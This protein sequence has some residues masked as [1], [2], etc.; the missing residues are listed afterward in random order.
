MADKLLENKKLVRDLTVA[1]YEVD[2]KKRLRPSAFMDYAQ[3]IAYSAAQT[4]HFGYDD[5]GK[6]GC[7]WVISRLHFHYLKVPHWRDE[8]SLRTW[9]KGT[10]GPFFLRDFEILGKDGERMVVGTSNWIVLDSNARKMARDPNAYGLISPEYICAESA[11]DEVCGKVMMPHGVQP[12][13][14]GTH[15]VG[16]NDVDFIGHTN[17]SRYMAWAMNAVD[18]ADTLEMDIRD[19]RIGFNHETHDGDLVTIRRVIEQTQKGRRYCLEGQV[20]GKTS[21]VALIE[22]ERN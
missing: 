14:V 15:V 18:Y 6:Y 17:N 3:D 12:E 21:F 7:A 22:L 9:A 1:C 2:M 20:E 13:V 16:Y 19:V 11:I 10:E 5:M 8:L 4:L